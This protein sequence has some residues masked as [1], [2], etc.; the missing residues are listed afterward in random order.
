MSSI[1]TINSGDLIS[2]S[3]TDINTNFSN[4][5]TDKIETSY[6][7]T[8]TTLAANSDVKIATQKATK[9]Y[10]D[11]VASPTGRSWNEYAVDSVGTDSYA[12]TLTGFTAY[13][14]GQTFKFKAATANT[15]SCSLNVNGL[16]AKTIKKN[17]TANMA[18]G[19]ILAGQIVVVIYDGTDMQ[20]VS[21]IP[22]TSEITAASFQQDLALSVNDSFTTTEFT[23]GSMTDGSAFFVY[24]QGNLLL[25]RFQRD[26]LTGQYYQSHSISPTLQIPSGDN[27]A[28]INI[29]IYIYVFSNDGTNVVVSRFLAADLTGEQVMTVPTVACTAGVGAW[30]DGTDAYLVSNSSQTTSRKWTL[31]GTTFSASSTATVTTSTF[32]EA[33]NA[34]MWDGVSAY[35]ARMGQSPSLVYK[36]TNIDA[37]TFSTTS[38]IKPVYSDVQTGS[39]ILN[40][41]STKMYI[42]FMYPA[43]DEA[44]VISARIRLTPMSKP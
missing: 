18:T 5:N 35:M 33:Q 15:G 26:A 20:L 8:D 12:I 27:G 44:G 11:S 3:R 41:D 7:D 43:Y 23:A 22:I 2:G 13:V 14:A 9:A 30:T 31:S 29:G 39:F 28:I 34:T 36:L 10:V 40:I 6:L 37:S 21:K 42:G 32:S 24:L 17:A 1:T 4:L 25:Y 38:Y 19:D 16:G